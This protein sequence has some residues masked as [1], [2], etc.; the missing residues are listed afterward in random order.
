MQCTADLSDVARI[1]VSIA[2]KL[3]DIAILPSIFASITSLDETAL[4]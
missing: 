4:T 2:V 1:L 3:D